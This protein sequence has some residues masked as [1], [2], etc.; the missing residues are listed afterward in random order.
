[1]LSR[2]QSERT[3]QI[4]TWY[5]YHPCHSQYWSNTSGSSHLHSCRIARTLPTA[6]PTRR[7]AAPDRTCCD[8]FPVKAALRMRPLMFQVIASL[9]PCSSRWLMWEMNREQLSRCVCTPSGSRPEACPWLWSGSCTTQVFL[10]RSH[11]RRCSRVRR[12]PA[13]SKAILWEPPQNRT[14]SESEWE[15]VSDRRGSRRKRRRWRRRECRTICSS[16]WLRN[17]MI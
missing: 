13:A 6:V 9:W 1:M 5:R 11:C 15:C 4:R 14:A 2:L 12:R 8:G 7:A 16:F 10:T 17:K 3:L